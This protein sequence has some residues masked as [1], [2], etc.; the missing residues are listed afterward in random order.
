MKTNLL[1]PL[2]YPITSNTNFYYFELPSSNTTGSNLSELI[3]KYDIYIDTE[4][5]ITNTERILMDLK[6][7]KKLGSNNKLNLQYKVLY[8]DQNNKT[9][10]RADN[11][12]PYQ[13]IDLELP[14]RN[15][16]KKVFDTDPSDYEASINS[17]LRYAEFYNNPMIGVNYWLFNLVSFKKEL[18]H[19]FFN[20]AN[21]S[22]KPYTAF[23]DIA[24]LISVDIF[25]A[26]QET[27]YDFN[28]LSNLI[29]R[30][31]I[32]CKIFEEQNRRPLKI[33]K[34]LIQ[35]G[36]K[37]NLLPFPIFADSKTPVTRKVFDRNGNELPDIQV[38]LKG[39]TS[40]M[41]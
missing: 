14:N 18:I 16:E 29:V 20:T 21:T 4:I 36:I 1:Y 32:H 30:K 34:N 6:L 5:P 26:N 15:K 3:Q 23:T 28:S 12:H 27:Y 9:I 11:N 35:T 38:N 10:I 37:T 33:S 41:K 17:V 19:S 24:R 39:K 2:S 40:F 13:H 7:Y 31:F 8:Q 25:S 22:L